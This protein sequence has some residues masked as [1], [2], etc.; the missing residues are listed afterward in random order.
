MKA[1]ALANATASPA[2]LE[3]SSSTEDRA[4]TLISEPPDAE[5]RERTL[6]AEVEQPFWKQ[7]VYS[8]LEL[9]LASWRL[10]NKDPHLVYT[11]L[12]LD[13]VDQ[14]VLS[15]PWFQGWFEYVEMHNLAH[16]M[17]KVSIL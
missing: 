4:G 17:K 2:P 13:K 11:K 16:P 10:K 5:D 14:D 15:N 12:Q 3:T 1:D 7:D 6:L 9:K 8:W